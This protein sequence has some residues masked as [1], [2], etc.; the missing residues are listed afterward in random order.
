MYCLAMLNNIMIEFD[1]ESC[2]DN[3]HRQTGCKNY[4]EVLLNSSNNYNRTILTNPVGS[5]EKEWNRNAQP[6][7]TDMTYV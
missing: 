2:D 4:H 6:L 5:L 7:L 3:R 1:I